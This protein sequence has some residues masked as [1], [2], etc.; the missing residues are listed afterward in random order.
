MSRFAVSLA[1]MLLAAC[2][3]LRIHDAPV[4]WSVHQLSVAEIEA[5]I[6]AIQ[7]DLPEVRS[8][9]LRKIYVVDNDTICL[10]YGE[11]SE[12]FQNTYE[13]K[14]SRGRWHYTGYIII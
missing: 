5:A 4:Y 12:R 3:P 10:S 1:A 2:A 8:Q 11:A 14:R 13:V 7:S 9:K 6:A